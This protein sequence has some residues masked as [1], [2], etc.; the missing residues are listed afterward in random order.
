MRAGELGFFD[1]VKTKFAHLSEAE[2][3]AIHRLDLRQVP[4]QR[5]EVVAVDRPDVGEPQILE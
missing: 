5:L 2:M 4:A 1:K 3:R